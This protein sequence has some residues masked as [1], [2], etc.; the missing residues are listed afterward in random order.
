[1]NV[2][3]ALLDRS[4]LRLL[5]CEQL[6]LLMQ[7]PGWPSSRVA[8]NVGNDGKVLPEILRLN[9]LSSDEPACIAT[10]KFSPTHMLL[11]NVF[12]VH[13]NL[14]TDQRLA[15]ESVMEEISTSCRWDEGFKNTVLRARV[16]LEFW[17]DR[18]SRRKEIYTI[19]TWLLYSLIKRGVIV[20][21]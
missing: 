2:P 11:V 15:L 3:E 9:Q 5:T 1:M 20:I 16:P 19:I 14:D 13:G 18:E 6:I 8:F 21:E 12:G 4:K 7:E 17:D 10:I